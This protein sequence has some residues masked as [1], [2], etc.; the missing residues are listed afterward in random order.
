MRWGTSWFH[1]MRGNSW[2]A[3]NLLASQ[4]GLWSI[5][6]RQVFV[7]PE[8][9][10]RQV[11]VYRGAVFGCLV[12]QA[13]CYSCAGI[14]KYFPR[15]WEVVTPVR[16]NVFSR[17]LLCVLGSGMVI[18]CLYSNYKLLRQWHH[19]RFHANCS[20]KLF[21]FVFFIKYTTFEVLAAVFML[22]KFCDV[23]CVEW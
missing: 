4:E 21:L 18:V 16:V 11:L 7:I 22:N 10:W 19:Y 1:E 15:L 14:R 20:H 17:C 13:S 23:R 5:E 2:V 12:Q 8:F 9:R 3:E 6:L